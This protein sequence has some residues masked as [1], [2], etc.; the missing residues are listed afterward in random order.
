MKMRDKT[1]AWIEDDADE[2]SVIIKPLQRAGFHFNHYGNYVDAMERLEEIKESDLIL[3]DMI[4]PSGAAAPELNKE[5]FLGKNLLRRFREEFNIQKPAIV[6]SFSADTNGFEEGE[7]DELKVACLSKPIKP[8][9]L[10]AT[11]L[12][13][14]GMEN[15]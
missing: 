12:R 4:I 13:V 2:I 14:L 8:A 11:V 10:K 9:E 3:L 6:L 5:R 7:A 15:E 1:I